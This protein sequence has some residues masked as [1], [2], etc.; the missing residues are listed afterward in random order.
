MDMQ[1][2]KPQAKHV[3]TFPRNIFPPS[4]FLLLRGFLSQDLYLLSALS[5]FFFKL[6]NPFLNFRK[7]LESTVSV[8]KSELNF[9]V[10]TELWLTVTLVSDGLI[11]QLKP[12]FRPP[13]ILV[14][15]EG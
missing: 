9:T 14:L 6:S 13:K 10:W 4:G 15:Q 3:T 11:S 5:I 1:E 2:K 7:L 8:G 12:K